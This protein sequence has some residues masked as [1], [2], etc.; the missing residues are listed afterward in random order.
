MSATPATV[1]ERRQTVE[2]LI[3]SG[4]TAVLTMA[5]IVYVGR[6]VG[7]AE[8]ADF[9][10]ALST[11]YLVGMAVTPLTPILARMTAQHVAR[12]AQG[13]VID[14]RRTALKRV[15]AVVGAASALGIAVSVP[16]SRA[17]HFRTPLPIVL[18][19]ISVLF[20]ALVNVERGVAQ[21]LMLFRAYNAN[22]IGEVICRLALGVGF[23]F[24][25]RSASAALAGYM[26]AL[27]IAEITLAFRLRRDTRDVSSIPADWSGVRSLMIAMIALMLCLAVF[28][29]VDI[30]A[31]KR[32]FSAE[33]AGA[34]AGA[35]VLARGV[36]VIFVPFYVIAGPLLT[37]LYETGKPLHAATLRLVAGFATISGLA[38][39]ILA[40]IGERLLT[41]LYGVDF[42]RGAVILPALAAVATMTYA[43]IL[44]VQV[45]IARKE[46]GFLSAPIFFAVIQLV[47]LF[48]FHDTYREL[49]GA[50]IA[51]QGAM[52]L[53]VAALF[54]RSWRAEGNVA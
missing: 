28:Q 52:L 39:A 45:F 34:Y 43:A 29:N 37:S 5:Y 42:A 20:F 24:V 48:F 10:A 12:G 27:V 30:L 35:S 14:L 17:L 4:I 49:L 26:L 13:A 51:V 54:V 3:G 47:A 46:Y 31:V 33:D 8:Y 6:V 9:S 44:L 21:G 32:W 1:V 22:V 19:L 38:I 7:A 41:S 18:A 53:S 15:A 25:M 50:L 40:L 2:L 16:L 23:L 36:G 11:I